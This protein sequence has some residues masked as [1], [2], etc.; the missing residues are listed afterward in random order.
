MMAATNQRSAQ[1]QAQVDE[2]MRRLSARIPDSLHRQFKKWLTDLD[3]TD[4]HQGQH[5]AEAL[6]EYMRVQRQTKRLGLVR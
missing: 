2:A 4:Y 3:G 5:V 6:R 1:A